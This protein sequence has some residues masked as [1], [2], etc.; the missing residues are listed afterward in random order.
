MSE[1]PKIPE[2]PYPEIGFDWDAMRAAPEIH[3]TAW[4]A[5]D[6][7]VNGR[8]SVGPGSS[9]WHGCVIRGDRERIEIGRESNIQDG[10]I[11]H[12]DPGLPCVIGDRVTLGHRALVHA[13]TVEDDAMIAIG[14]TVLSG[15]RVGAG[16]LVA[17]GAVVLEGTQVSPG[18]VWAGCPA[19]PLRDVDE[20][21]AD[22]MRHAWQH[23]ANLTVLKLA[24]TG[25][26]KKAADS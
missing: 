20:A 18:T 12:I 26:R 14:A 21:L 8:V 17:A 13:A 19:K 7:I 9:V 5:D 11:L 22:R 1:L 15:A 3:E 10:A 4:V 2:V 16:A 23:Y 25:E 24:E 6:A